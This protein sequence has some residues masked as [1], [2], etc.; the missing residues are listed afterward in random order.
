MLIF[1]KLT[2]LKIIKFKKLKLNLINFGNEKYFDIPF[3]AIKRGS[4]LV[5]IIGLSFA[6]I[7]FIFEV[8]LFLLLNWSNLDYNKIYK[9]YANYIQVGNEI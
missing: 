7:T 8:T 9:I 1:G 2:S 4:L 3:D 5:L 6:F